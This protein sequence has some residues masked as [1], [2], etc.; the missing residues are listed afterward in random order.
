MKTVK[1]SGEKSAVVIEVPEPR[2]IKNWVK[3]KVH[4]APMCTEFKGFLAGDGCQGYGHE[5]VGEVIEVAQPCRVAVG[6]RVVV[7]PTNPC[8]VCTL[9]VAG[10]YIHCE[11]GVDYAAFTGSEHGSA[12]MSQYVLKADWLCSPIPEAVSYDRAALALCVLGPSFGAFEIMQVDAFDTVLITGLGPVGLGAIVNAKYRGA[13]VIGVEGNSFRCDLALS[14][15]AE[16][17]IDPRDADALAQV[18]SLTAGKGVDK[19]LDC[20]GVVAAHRLCIDATRRKGQV[21]FVGQC[22]AET[23]VCIGADLLTKGLHL[24]GAWHYNLSA[25]PRVMQVIQNANCID[26]LVTHRFSID[27]IQQAWETQVAG[28]CG[29]VILQPWADGS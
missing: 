13:R 17:I 11:N 10:N 28:N 5:A 14:L 29:K 23:P 26:D 12:T 4:A 21:A 18:R 25:Y 15:G 9:C 1:I 16:Q 24:H 27:D 19:S 6:D 2:A 20:S 7:Q 8:G 3:I 22:S